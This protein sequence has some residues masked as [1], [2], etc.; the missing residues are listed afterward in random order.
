MKVEKLFIEP[1]RVEDSGPDPF[2]VRAT[3]C[4][5]LSPALAST[6]PQ[7]TLRPYPHLY[8]RPHI[9]ARCLTRVRCSTTC[10]RSPSERARAAVAAVPPARLLSG[11]T[12]FLAHVMTPS[13]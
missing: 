7:P 6:L 4:L 2:E 5:A 10:A 12:L 8:F 13:P 11:P 1:G 9:R 3:T